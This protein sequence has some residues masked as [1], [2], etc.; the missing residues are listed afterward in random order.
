MIVTA[1]ASSECKGFKMQESKGRHDV[2][3][4]LETRVLITSSAIPPQP[5]LLTSLACHLPLFL[6][7][8]ISFIRH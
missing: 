1:S 3:V 8:E 7:P 4:A 2:P 5:R 6:A